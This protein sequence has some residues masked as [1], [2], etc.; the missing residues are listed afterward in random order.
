MVPVVFTDFYLSGVSLDHYQRE[1][2]FI[3][4][5]ALLGAAKSSSDNSAALV[6]E[7]CRSVLDCYLTTREPG[8]ACAVMLRGANAAQQPR[9]IAGG[10]WTASLLMIEGLGTI[11][12]L[13]GAQL[14][15]S[16]IAQVLYN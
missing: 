13:W 14:G 7:T 1:A 11:C 15:S 6:Y 9:V 4:N 3:L 2:I 16:T 12:R 8:G 10:E 5:E